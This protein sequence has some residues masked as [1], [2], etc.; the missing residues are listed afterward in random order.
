MRVVS[1]LPSATEIVAA[2]GYADAIVGVSHECDFPP[3]V[4]TRDVVTSSAIDATAAPDRIDRTVRD[5]VEAGRPLYDVREARVRALAPDLMVTQVVCDVCAVSEDEVR[6]LATR[7][8]PRPEVVTLGATTLDGIFDDI[9]RVAT[10][11]G[12]VGRGDALV[13]RMRARMRAV[14]E[15]L[16][17]ARA[18]RPRVAVVEWTDP[19]FAAGHWVPEMVYRAGGED[20]L[21]EPGEHSRVRTLDSVRAADPE[22]VVIAPCGFDLARAAADAERILATPEWEWARDRQ[23]WAVDANAFLSRPGPR[24]V[25]GIELLAAVFNPSLFGAV[26]P[27]NGRRIDSGAA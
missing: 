7:L 16:E 12:D 3:A 8:Q 22:I 11:L 23:V 5:L 17:A 6:G 24:V 19:L 20:V 13:E 21:A 4:R 10:A 15:T 1:F 27:P 14:H 25:D 26:I 9:R 18:P 2:L